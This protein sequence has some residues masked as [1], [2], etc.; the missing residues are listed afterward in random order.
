[1][2]AGHPLRDGQTLR[3]ADQW[4]EVI[5][6]PGHTSDSICLYCAEEGVLFSGDTSLM[7]TDTGSSYQH[8]FARALE[9]IARRDI[10]AIC[11]GHGKPISRGVKQSIYR[12][13]DNVRKSKI[14]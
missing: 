1:M 13:L 7:I 8:D 10:K 6:T 4:F 11:P 12:S 14:I 2:L 5:H 9:R 3:L